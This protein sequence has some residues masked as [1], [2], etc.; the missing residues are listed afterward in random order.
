MIWIVTKYLITAAVLVLMS[1]V[2][3]RSD[4]LVVL[5]AK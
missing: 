1:E 4:K 2:A 5:I 3:K